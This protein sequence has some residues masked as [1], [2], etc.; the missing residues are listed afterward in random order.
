MSNNS[1]VQ[2]QT[3]SFMDTYIN[4][5]FKMCTLVVT[6]SCL[7]AG[8]SFFSFKL[9]GILPTVSWNG[10]SVFIATTIVYLIGGIVIIRN[11]YTEDGKLKPSSLR[12][13]KIYL[14]A[15]I[16]IQWNFIQYLIPSK[17]F[18]GF[19]FYFILC[20]AF[21]LDYKMVVST[22]LMIYLS[23][24][25][26]FFVRG[27]IMLPNRD[28]YFIAE[29]LITCIA[30]FLS[31]VAMIGLTYLI[32]R[33]L[34]EAGENM[35]ESKN[36]ILNV[37]DKVKISSHELGNASTL[38]LERVMSQSASTKK[39]ESVS[40][41]LQKT[42][43][44]MLNKSVE[45]KNK[46]HQLAENETDM[47]ESMIEVGSVSQE[48]EDISKANEIALQDLLEIS[49]SVDESTKKTM[50]VTS[51][52]LGETDEITQ[53]L[54]IINEIATSINL[55]SLNASIEAARAGEAGRGFAVVAG[56]VGKLAASTRE[57]LKSVESVVNR[58][59]T[60]TSDVATFM[61]QNAK[62]LEN[63]NSVLQET[64][65][66][67]QNMINLLKKSN[68]AIKKADELQNIQQ[69]IINETVSVN[70]DLAERINQ[71]NEEF[72]VISKMVH[73]S[74]D[75]IMVLSSQVDKIN[76]MIVELEELV[77]KE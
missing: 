14:V 23:I 66:G 21:F 7:I 13:A 25:I 29:L 45:S 28:E 61:E 65:T 39:L 40:E 8:I 55:L 17:T 18:W 49:S 4:I 24:T 26:G 47:L 48:L 37:L 56:E 50:D 46:L 36:R 34:G 19:C 43:E 75:D 3:P 35:E 22:T 41:E 69:K 42:N 38:L 32:G 27:D 77:D 20:I 57:S 72:G 59:Q 51:K 62:Q 68:V 52:L 76:E 5:V 54:N 64:V 15:I 33:F 16:L 58:V 10:L 74:T 60:G 11:A 53:T 1:S 71:E 63:Q 30:L 9:F 6:G 12:F 70:D 31:G 2:Q 67:L 73:N 44:S